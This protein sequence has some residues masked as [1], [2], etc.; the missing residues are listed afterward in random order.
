MQEAGTAEY[1]RQGL[2][3]AA[4]AEVGVAG[5]RVEGG[6]HGRIEEAGGCRRQPRQ[7]QGL[8]EAG[9]ARQ[10]LKEVGHGIT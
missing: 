3:E 6:G 8:Q 4:K 5:A 10:G 1:R 7:R 9:T 2:L